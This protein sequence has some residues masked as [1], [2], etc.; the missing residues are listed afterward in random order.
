MNVRWAYILRT[1]DNPHVQQVDNS[2]NLSS[3]LELR[4]DE[5]AEGSGVLYLRSAYQGTVTDEID[6]RK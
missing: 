3:H 5:L 1:S 2:R 4:S 6:H